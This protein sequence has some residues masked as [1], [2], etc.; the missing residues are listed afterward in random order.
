M[1]PLPATIRHRDLAAM[2]SRA[3]RHRDRGQV[4]EPQRR[5]HVG[6]W[7]PV[8][9]FF[10]LLSPFAV[11]LA[12][13][14]TLAPPLRGVNPYAAVVMLGQVLTSMSGTKV[15]VDTPDVRVRITIL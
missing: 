6:L 12:P 1:N 13:F 5:R 4:D 15:H 3:L 2:Q 7:L 11:L 14:L 9:P 10:W 8:T